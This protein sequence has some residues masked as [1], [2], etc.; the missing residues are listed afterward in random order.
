MMSGGAY[1]AE[2]IGQFATQQQVNRRNNRTGRSSGGLQAAWTDHCIRIE[3]RVAPQRSQCLHASEVVSRVHSQELT[4]RDF[5]SIDMSQEI[6]KMSR[7]KLVI[8]GRQT[9]GILRMSCTSI[10][11]MTIRVTDVSCTQN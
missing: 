10:M 11:C 3:L 6:E 1:A 9:A 8:Y 7:Y 4:F 2:G 5:R